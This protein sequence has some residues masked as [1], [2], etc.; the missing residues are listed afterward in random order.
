MDE[1]Y[2]LNSDNIDKLHKSLNRFERDKTVKSVLLFMADTDK[3]SD[4]LLEPILQKFSKPIIGGVFPELIFKG[5]RKKTGTLIIPL[6][7]KLNTQIIKLSDSQDSILK[8]LEEVQKH[9][10]DTSSSLFVFFDALG[11]SKRLFIQSLFNFFGVNPTY[12]GAGAGSLNFESFPCIYNNSGI[13]KNVAVIGWAKKEV[14][15]GVAHGWK[16][17]SKPLKA[18][19]TFKNEVKSI[20][21]EPAFKVYKNIVEKHSKK[22]FNN[23]NFFEIAKSYPLGISKIEAEKVVR[24]PFKIVNNNIHFVSSIKQGEYIEVLHGNTNSLLKSA[25]TAIDN[26]INNWQNKPI[27]TVFCVDCISRALFMGNEFNKEL[28]IIENKGLT[29]GILGIG[30]IANT[31]NSFLEIY[32]KTIVMAIW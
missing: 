30:E 31:G 32:N 21:W 23:F 8:Q 26:S 15:I 24:D 3:F 9:S 27:H 1:L 10:T 6:E 2:L 17:I 22:T 25:A 11:K 12:I 18:T 13:H 7:F 16:P 29:S 4:T 20:N 19:E 28:E 5:K 14:A